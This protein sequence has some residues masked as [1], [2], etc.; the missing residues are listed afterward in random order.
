MAR[1]FVPSSALCYLSGCK[2]PKDRSLAKGSSLPGQLLY[3]RSLLERLHCGREEALKPLCSTG[4]RGC[5]GTSWKWVGEV[6]PQLLHLLVGVLGQGLFPKRGCPRAPVLARVPDIWG[7]FSI[8]QVELLLSLTLSGATTSKH[9]LRLFLWKDGTI[10][11][12]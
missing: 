2:W 5:P 9:L 11:C 4:G 3:H 6:L 10:C 1:L 7:V 12:S 8:S